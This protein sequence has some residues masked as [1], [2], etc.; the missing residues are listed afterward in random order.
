MS[1]SAFDLPGALPWVPMT[2]T[3]ALLR[4]FDFGIDEEDAAGGETAA[5]VSASPALVSQ[6]VEGAQQRQ[7]FLIGALGLMVGYAQ[8]SDLTEMPRVHR[9]PHAP[10]WF[11]GICN[12]HG[13]LVPVF[14]LALRLGVE[15]DARARPMLLV[16]GHGADAAGMV[17]DGI[18][19]RLRF[20]ADALADAAT[21]PDL[22][23]GLVT[24][25][26]LIGER[27]W[28]DLDVPALLAE[29]E[30]ALGPPQ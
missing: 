17:V 25:A 6:P 13:A 11:A 29:L 28:F 19:T 20:T 16:L 27:L 14:D 3:A 18:P 22:L 2:P 8:G 7:G 26:A 10:A 4:G 23:D 30:R 5:D 24:R 9:L 21:V 12:L 15:R 1:D